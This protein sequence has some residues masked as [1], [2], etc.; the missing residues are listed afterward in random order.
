MQPSQAECGSPPHTPPAPFPPSLSTVFPT[1]VHLLYVFGPA[2]P[3][4]S[5]TIILAIDV[6]PGLSILTEGG[7]GAR[8]IM[9]LLGDADLPCYVAL[10]VR[11]LPPW[12]ITLPLLTQKWKRENERLPK[13]LQR[14]I[15]E[16]PSTDLTQEEW[17]QFAWETSQVMVSLVQGLVRVN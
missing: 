14:P 13:N 7:K 11:F 3:R 15:P 6:R 5:I 2:S 17:N 12:V 16:K 9:G 10:R 4:L 1:V 8:G